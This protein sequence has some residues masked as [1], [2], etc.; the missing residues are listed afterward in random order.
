M[1][2]HVRH[3]E[4]CV[5]PQR[6]AQPA[7]SLQL[8]LRS[9]LCF[10]RRLGSPSSFAPDVEK[11]FLTLVSCYKVGIFF[12]SKGTQFNES[13]ISN[14]EVNKMGAGGIIQQMLAVMK[15]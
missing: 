4:E 11:L 8:G 12:F 14:E 15:C 9:P 2:E 3:S 5:A 7:A 1:S 6:P 10:L 13:K